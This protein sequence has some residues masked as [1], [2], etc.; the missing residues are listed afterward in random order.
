VLHQVLHF[1][2]VQMPNAVHV[3]LV[4]LKI[5]SHIS[6]AR[7]HAHAHTCMKVM[8]LQV[9]QVLQVGFVAL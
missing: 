9:L 8:L 6:H 3:A 4:A 2:R 7:A 5:R 1:L